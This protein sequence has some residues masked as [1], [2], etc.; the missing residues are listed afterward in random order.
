MW[1]SILAMV[2][3][4]SLVGAQT[5]AEDV[6]QKPA[7]QTKPSESIPLVSPKY[8]HFAVY[9]AIR[10]GTAEE[11]AIE[12]WPGGFVTVPKSPVSGL[13]LS[14]WTCSHWRVLR[15]A[16]SNIPSLSPARS[17]SRHSPFWRL[18]RRPRFV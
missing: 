13:F 11:V 17:A 16:R 5:P 12:F 8:E 7:S 6:I 1:R 14:S 2:L 9:D 3:L 15:S 10:R 4:P 18:D